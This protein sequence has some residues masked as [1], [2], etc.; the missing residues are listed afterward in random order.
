MKLSVLDRLI[1]LNVLPKEN[2]VTTLRIIRKLKEELSFTEQE[3]KMLQFV[4][5]EKGLRWNIEADIEKDVEIGEKATD[6]IAEAFK[7]LSS[8]KKLHEEH[9]DIYDKF[10]KE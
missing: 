6:I 1:I 3:Y 2:D 7:T 9:L 10:V 5:D 8:Q 4:G